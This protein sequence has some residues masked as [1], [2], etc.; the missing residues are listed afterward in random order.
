MVLSPIKPYLFRLL[1]CLLA[2]TPC[3]MKTPLLLTLYLPLLP[4]E[5]LRPSWSETGAYVV[6][7]GGKVLVASAEATN[8]GVRVGMRSGGVATIA[9]GAIML[10]RDTEKE[11][12][13]LDS[14]A[15]AM[16]QFTPEVAFTDDFS[17]LLDV[18]VW[19]S[20]FVVSVGT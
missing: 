11:S 3:I 12:R 20:A 7:D 5:T 14:I 6:V 13:A 17:L 1:I 2:V 16:L 8:A 19:R 4:L 10:D 9:P 18:G 15:M